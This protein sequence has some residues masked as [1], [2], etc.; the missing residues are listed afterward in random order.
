MNCKEAERRIYLYREL[1]SREREETE[2]HMASCPACREL[3]ARVSDERKMLAD[4][5]RAPHVAPDPLRLTQRIMSRVEQTRSEKVFVIGPLNFIAVGNTLRYAMAVL[6]VMLIATFI[7]DYSAT[8]E[9]TS[10]FTASEADKSRLN[11]SSFLEILKEKNKTESS[12]SVYHCVMSCLQAQD[13]NCSECGT[14]FSNFINEHE[15][16]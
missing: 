7:S 14:K 5:M 11:S 13:A 4:L 6:S 15:A 9:T 16:I 3:G 8:P 1:T 2:A 12:S 10:S